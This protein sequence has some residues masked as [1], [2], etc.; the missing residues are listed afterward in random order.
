[1]GIGLSRREKF[2]EAVLAELQKYKKKNKKKWNAIKDKELK[3]Y[4]FEITV[5]I[6]GDN[7]EYIGSH[8]EYL[9]TLIKFIKAKKVAQIITDVR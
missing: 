4:T 6:E 2:L 7:M 3:D 1:M 9:Y 5:N 8:K